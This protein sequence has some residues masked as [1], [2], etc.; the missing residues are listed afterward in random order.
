MLAHLVSCG[1]T[2][3]KNRQHA[4]ERADVGRHAFT[5]LH[6]DATSGRSRRIVNE[7]PGLGRRLGLRYLLVE[8]GLVLG[9]QLCEFLLHGHEEGL[10]LM[11]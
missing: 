7:L 3:R 1:L 10:L 6:D 9:K 5:L 4:I 2:R 11:S 8:D